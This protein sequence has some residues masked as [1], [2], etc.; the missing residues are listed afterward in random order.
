MKLATAYCA[1][2][3]IS[4]IVA[5]F[6]LS[7]SIAVAGLNPE[8]ADEV[9]DA[10]WPHSRRKAKRGPSTRRGAPRSSPPGIRP[11]LPSVVVARSPVILLESIATPRRRHSSCA[12]LSAIPPT[13]PRLMLLLSLPPRSMPNCETRRVTELFP[14]LSPTDEDNTAL[15]ASSDTLCT[16]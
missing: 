10:Y 4:S 5:S 16:A 1:N 8:E 13:I 9:L 14:I 2:L 15:V 6:A 3:E 7:S 12:V 11:L